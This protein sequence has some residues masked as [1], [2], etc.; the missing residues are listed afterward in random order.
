MFVATETIRQ[1]RA[2]R[3]QGYL[4]DGV[5]RIF[6]LADGGEPAATKHTQVQ[7]IQ[8]RLYAMN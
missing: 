1:S 6:P 7:S 5:W 2:E 8:Q 4:G 3:A